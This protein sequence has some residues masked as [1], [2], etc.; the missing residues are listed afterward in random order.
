M[1][2]TMT[3]KAHISQMHCSTANWLDTHAGAAC[4][5]CQCYMYMAD[6]TQQP[7]CKGAWSSLPTQHSTCTTDTGELA[8]HPHAPDRAQGACFTAPY[9]E[10]HISSLVGS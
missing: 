4:D 10:R 5:T 7:A 1:T 9:C 2:M 8:V 6:P 3:C